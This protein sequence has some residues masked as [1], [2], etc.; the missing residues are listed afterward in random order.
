MKK[1]CRNLFHVNG[2]RRAA[3]WMSFLAG[4]TEG[5]GVE[6][7]PIDWQE[8]SNGDLLWGRDLF[9]SD[10]NQI[11]TD[12]AA[13]R[14]HDHPLWRMAEITCVLLLLL[15]AAKKKLKLFC[16]CVILLTCN[17]IVRIFDWIR[18]SRPHK[19]IECTAD[20]AHFKLS[21]C[22]LWNFFSLDW[23]VQSCS[24]WCQMRGHYVFYD[25]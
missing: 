2:A 13:N 18:G 9:P 20:S 1:Q 6:S 11:G 25:T 19:S 17:R 16:V 22:E 14:L 10:R 5:A 23:I 12:P 8:I 21:V 24:T 4:F 7:G 15:R 3:R